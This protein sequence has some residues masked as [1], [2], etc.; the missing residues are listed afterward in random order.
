MPDRPSTQFGSIVKLRCPRCRIG[1]L[2]PTSTY[3]FS[4]P[5]EMPRYCSV[6][7]QDFYPEPGFY[8]GAMFASYIVFSFPCLGFVILL[9][10][11]FEVSLGASMFWLCVV[12]GLGFIYVFRVSRSLWIHLNVRYD[13]ALSD[14]LLRQSAKI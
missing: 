13:E 3:G 1:R 10:W 5:F 14:E 9:H 7:E 6:C 12:A 11:V 8:Y 2:F 4:E